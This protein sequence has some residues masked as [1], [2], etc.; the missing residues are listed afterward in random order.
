M[1]KRTIPILLQLQILAGLGFAGSADGQIEKI[2]SQYSK[3]HSSLAEDSTEGVDAAAKSI[4]ELASLLKSADPASEKLGE[5]IA[6]AA[7]SI[8]GE[9]LEQTRLE[10]FE[11]SKPLLVYLNTYYSGKETYYRFYCDMAKKGWVQSEKEIRNPYYG[12]SM[13]T[14]GELIK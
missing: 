9:N 7:Q 11:L 6:R 13:L 12:S 2:L 4:Q 14:C 10:F 8:Q 3:I 5:D 1:M